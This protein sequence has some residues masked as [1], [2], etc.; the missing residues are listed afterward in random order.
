MQQQKNVSGSDLIQQTPSEMSICG[1]RCN[2]VEC[3]C[4]TE[5]MILNLL[6]IYISV[7]MLTLM[8]VLSNV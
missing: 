2:F 6:L 1:R 4:E 7:Y 8:A 3:A 5:E